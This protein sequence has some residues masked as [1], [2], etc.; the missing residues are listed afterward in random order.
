MLQENSFRKLEMSNLIKHIAAL[1]PGPVNTE[2]HINRTGL[3][4]IFPFYHAVS[5]RVLPHTKHLYS[6][7]SRQQFEDDLE[8]LLG[9][10]EPVK[11]S[12][13]LEGK[14]HGNSQRP[15]M[16]LSFDDGLIQCYE[17]IMPVLKKKSIPATFF[18]NNAFI[19]N[20]AMFFRYKVSLL[21]ELLPD[22]SDHEKEKAAGILHCNVSELRKRLLS[23]SYFERDV[24][25]Q[26]AELWNYSF[27]DYLRM[28]PVYL[29]TPHIN[30]MRDEGFEFGS[31]GIDHPLFSSLSAQTAIDHIRNSVFDLQ[32]RYG[33][34]Y[35]Y[36]AF[37]FTDYGVQDDTIDELFRDGIIDAGFG[38]AGL[39]EDRW[40][41]YFQRVPMELMGLDARKVLRGELNRRCIRKIT[42]KNR[43]SR[44]KQN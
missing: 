36:F 4:V 6:L 19:D 41:A 38:T 30:E 2:K 31:H 7:R 22:R 9:Q 37:P 13:F 43:V 24:T 40:P 28:S 15:P 34:D 8:T 29:F 39:K 26:L 11:M 35:K 20:K 32:N 27:D 21:L 23:V 33:L 3:E 25:D 12:E 17:E 1:V 44:G 14:T 16:V 18:L 42:G 5:D 10:F